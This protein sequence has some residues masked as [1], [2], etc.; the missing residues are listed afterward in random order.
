MTAIREIKPLRVWSWTQISFCTDSNVIQ[1]LNHQRSPFT[2]EKS[3]RSSQIQIISTQLEC[4][5]P[6]TERVVSV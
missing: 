3:A 1:A 4:H 5:H 2:T 6:R